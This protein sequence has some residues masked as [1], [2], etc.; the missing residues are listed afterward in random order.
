M[1]PGD[2]TPERRGVPLNIVML[3][4]PGAGKG[5]QASH[6]TRRWKIP[7]ISTGAMLRDAV[8]AGTELGRQ[9][10]AII[11]AGC[12]IDDGLITAIVRERLS[13]PD[14]RRGFLLDGFPRTVPQA[15]ALDALLADR[16]LLVV[17]LSLDDEVIVKRLASRMVCTDC[18]T[19]RQDDSGDFEH[20]AACGGHLVV[21]SDDQEQVVRRRLEVYHAQT[22]PLVE[23]YAQRPGF[24]RV[25]GDQYFDHV[26]AD[27]SRAIEA[28]IGRR[29]GVGV[30]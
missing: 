10:D 25:D 26:A 13:L 20:C 1:D 12:L 23:W 22:A 3:G 27:I 21:R 19:N 9:V 30:F 24:C 17:E 18:G 4:P 15:Q 6:L 16:S 7:H 29:P 11:S 2:P 14:T 28:I 5:T 8:R